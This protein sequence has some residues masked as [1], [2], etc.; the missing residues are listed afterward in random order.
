MV[1]DLGYFERKANPISLSIPL[2]REMKALKMK[3]KRKKNSLTKIVKESL[4]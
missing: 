3:A 2:E 1:R 4:F